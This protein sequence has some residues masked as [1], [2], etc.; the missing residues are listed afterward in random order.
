MKKSIVILIALAMVSMTPTKHFTLTEG[1]AVMN[2]NVLET[3]R[4]IIP[5]SDVLSA[6]EASNCLM[7]IDSIQKVLIRQVEFDTTAVKK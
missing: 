7:Q 4:K 5:Y 3:A 2:Y 6:K 1:Q